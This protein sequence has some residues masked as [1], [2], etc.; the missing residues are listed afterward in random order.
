MNDRIIA[1][2]RADSLKGVLVAARRRRIRRRATAVVVVGVALALVYVLLNPDRSTLR[3]SVAASTAAVAP[4]SP[5]P[6]D[7]GPPHIIRTTSSSLTRIS[8]TS[9]VTLVR[10]QTPPAADVGRIDTPTMAGFFPGSGIVV[11]H[12]D[13]ET[14]R[15]VFF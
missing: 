12:R 7:A 10:L 9:S 4:A 11:I 6:R 3:R 13:S 2:L 8:T 14:P 1:D 15:A 5:V